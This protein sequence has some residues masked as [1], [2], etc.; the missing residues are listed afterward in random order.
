LD[1]LQW[2]DGGSCSLLFHLG[3]RI[4]GSRI[5]I[6]GAYRPSEV[7]LGRA[8]ER[9]PLETALNEVRRL[10][11]DNLLDLGLVEGRAFV[12]AFLDS[13]PNQLNEEF[14]QSLFAL[15]QGQPLATVELLRGLQERGGLV[16]DNAGRWSVGSMLDWSA[17]PARVEAMIAERVARLDEQQ[18]H[19]LQVAGV[20]GETFT[21][22]VVARVV[23]LAEGDAIRLLSEDLD[24]GHRLVRAEGVRRQDGQR[25]STYR[26]RH[27]LIQKYLYSTLDAVERPHL[28]DAIASALQALHREQTDDVAG[29]LARHFTAAGATDQAADF[30][31]R[32][33]DRAGALI[34]P[35]EAAQYYLAAQSAY[36]QAYG[37]GWNPL[38]QV[39]LERK[40]GEALFRQ[41]NYQEAAEHLQRALGLLGIGL[42]EG[43]AQ[44]QLALLGQIMRQAVHRLLPRLST[45]S[46]V[47]AIPEPIQQEMD[48]SYLISFIDFFSSRQERFLLLAFRILNLAESSGCVP[49]IARSC[50]GL[51]TVFDFMSLGRLA[52]S[53]STR[54]VSLAEQLQDPAALAQAHHAAAHHAWLSGQWDSTL[55]HGER[56]LAVLGEAGGLRERTT[57]VWVVASA[58]ICKGDAQR[59]LAL[60][61]ELV[62]TGDENADLEACCVGAGRAGRALVHL[63]RMEDAQRVLERA[64]ELAD[65]V[66]DDLN[67][68]EARGDLAKCLL[69]QGKREAALAALEE[70]RRL[71]TEHHVQPH[72]A[73]PFWAGL[74]EAYVQAAE[75]EAGSERSQWLGKTSQAIESALKNARRFRP[76]MAEVM[77]LRGTYEWVRGDRKSAQK[78]WQRSVELAEQLKMRYDLAISLLEMGSRRQDR[79]EVERAQVILLEIDAQQQAGARACPIG[80]RPDPST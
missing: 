64:V 80:S 2:A 63:G 38:E 50:A 56:S 68:V 69:R 57:A 33:G 17:L 42:P 3:K 24:R 66:P 62:R 58:L 23:G 70:A 1:D 22:E 67:R 52:R 41:G 31:K 71:A 44:V 11:G 79:A 4:A 7:A 37:E 74:V 30:L 6:L 46:A 8:G 15:S 73:A 48:I 40:I 76:A 13:E 53:Y 20:E 26:F 16:R 43:R 77:R 28:H 27:I 18:R 49:W 9:H 19:V 54:A 51:T 25:L 78:W 21:A 65:T 75:H 5:M 14:R 39:A 61:E 45:P 12:D 55:E 34:A 36:A 60:S 10:Y 29:E 72:N 35:G 47:G 59:A 32:A